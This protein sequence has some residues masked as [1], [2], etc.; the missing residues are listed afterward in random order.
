MLRDLI[1]FYRLV[2]I[3]HGGSDSICMCLVRASG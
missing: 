2:E 3:K 1:S